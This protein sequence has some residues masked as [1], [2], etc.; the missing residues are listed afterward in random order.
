MKIVTY[1]L[2]VTGSP[3]TTGYH[4]QLLDSVKSLRRYNRTVGIHAF[5]YG[6]Y[7]RQFVS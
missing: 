7:S 1:S 6:E 2:S 4:E 3:Q 5:L